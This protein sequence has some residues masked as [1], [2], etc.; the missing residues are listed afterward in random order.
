[1]YVFLFSIYYNF[2]VEITESDG[3]SHHLASDDYSLAFVFEFNIDLNI[4]F[5]SRDEI[6]DLGYVNMEGRKHCLLNGMIIDREF[7]NLNYDFSDV[8]VFVV[9]NVRGGVHIR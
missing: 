4:V 5:I 6:L 8:F 1:M 7:K 2:I 3:G 9:W